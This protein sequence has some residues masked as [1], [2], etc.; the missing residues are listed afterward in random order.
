MKDQI[1]TVLGPQAPGELGI[2]DAHNH[3]WITEQENQADQAPVLDQETEIRQELIAYRKAGGGSQLDCQPG[4]AGRDG[5]KLRQLSA[6]SGV[7]IV[8]C[9]GFHLREYYPLDAGLWSM[10]GDQAVDYFLGEIHEGLEETRGGSPTVHPGFIKIAVRE[11]IQKSPVHLMEA[12]SAASKQSGYL[13]QM[14]TQRGANAEAFVRF[15]LDHNL[16][17]DRLVISH[18][19]KRPDLGLHR[20]LAQAG[21]LLEYD[22]FFRPKYDPE[23]NLWP[24]ILSMVR[25]GYSSSIACATDLADSALWET[26]GR[27]P[28]LVGFINVIKKRLEDH[29]ADSPVVAKLMGENI[30]GR[31]GVHH[32]ESTT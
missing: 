8:A 31:L 2:T 15:F 10:D 21:C 24:L 4:G 5:N 23:N 29:I 32:K 7:K 25:E 1:M 11:T 13:I 20:E 14:H 6:S 9:T 27:G 12:A 19:D 16:P 3:L 30:A 22:T 17:L 18:L 28:G 26:M